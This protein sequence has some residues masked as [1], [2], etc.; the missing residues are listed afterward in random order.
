[1]YFTQ[2]LMSNPGRHFIWVIVRCNMFPVNHVRVSQK[3]SFIEIFELLDFH[4]VMHI[5][6]K[7][8]NFERKI[9]NRSSIPILILISPDFG[10]FSGKFGR[11][12]SIRVLE[13]YVIRFGSVIS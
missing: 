7:M 2:Q 6:A 8:S 9:N 5:G 13:Y 4:R 12:N 11:H 3:F 10:I 1:M